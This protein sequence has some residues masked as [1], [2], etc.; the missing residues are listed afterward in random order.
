MT[1]PVVQVETSKGTIKVEIN[2]AQAPKTAA[3]FLDLVN[4][5]FYNGLSSPL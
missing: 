3:N 2:T 4:K 5:G 1:N